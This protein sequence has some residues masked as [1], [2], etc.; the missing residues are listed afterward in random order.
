[1]LKNIS[2]RN[3]LAFLI[4]LV[5]FGFL[6]PGVYLSMLRINTSGSVDAPLAKI[7]VEFFDTSNSIL[8][9]ITELFQQQ[10]FFVA[11]MIFVFSVVIPVGK[12]LL[13]MYI[14]VIKDK[15]RANKI[16][17]FIK[18]IGKWSMCDVFVVAVF[19]SFLSTGSR[20]SGNKS[21]T[22]FLGIPIDIDIVV[23][24]K[25]QLEIGFYCFLTYCLL[26][27]IALQLYQ[28]IPVSKD[29]RHLMTK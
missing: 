19:L 5:A 27:L 1:M 24:M 21:E 29:E 26:S 6:I 9:T 14:I 25:A 20:T 18:A 8:T 16:F 2:L 28:D 10:Y 11:I 7:G 12:A 3:K 13:L 4:S 23:D 17:H 15:I 22:S